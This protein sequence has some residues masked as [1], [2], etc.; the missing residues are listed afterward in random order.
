MQRKYARS[1]DYAAITTAVLPLV[2][3]K[4]GLFRDTVKKE[5]GLA[6]Q[7][8]FSLCTISELSETRLKEIQVDYNERNGTSETIEGIK[9]IYKNTYFIKKEAQP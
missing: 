9:E 5:R 4:N 3:C 1:A 7:I 6:M 8:P 2:R